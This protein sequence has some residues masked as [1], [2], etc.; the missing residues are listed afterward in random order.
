MKEIDENKKDLIKIGLYGGFFLVVI[1]F[2]VIS[3]RT[4]NKSNNVNNSN[5]K[6][7]NS[8][9]KQIS[10]IDDNYF[11]SKVHLIMDDDAVS[12]EY[13][14]IGEVEIG[15]KKYHSENIEYTKYNDVYYKLEGN[16]FVRLSNFIDFD[17]DK[18]F[19]DIENIKKLL[20]LDSQNS[21][22]IS[23]DFNVLRLN[24]SVNDVIKI[25]NDYNDTNVIKYSDG[26]V[27]LDVYYKDD[28][29]SYLEMNVTDLYNLVNDKSLENVIYKLEF[30]SE[31]EEDVSWLIEKFN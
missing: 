25:Y 12:L 10:N 14:H 6:H 13:Q 17:Y 24:F 26:V 18:T 1:L 21:S 15:V 9:V 20:E 7:D 31:K 19:M 5:N 29:F 3:N 11:S 8:I 22:Y 4:G 28:N 16:N 27:I 23:N 2:A 30:K